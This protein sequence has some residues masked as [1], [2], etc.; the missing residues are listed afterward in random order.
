MEIIK[1]NLN[2]NGI[3]FFD[4]PYTAG[5]KKA[6]NRLYN[7]HELN[8]ELLFSF[9]YNI[10]YFLMTYDISDEIKF[11]AEKYDFEIKKI[12]MKNTHNTQ[13]KEYIISKNLKWA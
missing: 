8:H 13:M 7:H 11:L 4:P 1:D 12:P 3:F 10:N 9:C 2:S 6:G 5:G